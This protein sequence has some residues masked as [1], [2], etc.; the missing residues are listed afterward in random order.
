MS[1]DINEAGKDG[2]AA[3]VDYFGVGGGVDGSGGADFFDAIIFDEHVAVIDYF[4]AFHGDY[5]GAAQE[6]LAFGNFA[7]DFAERWRFFR[8]FH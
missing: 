6:E 8:A 3:D 4:F 1:V 2:F 5:A 7:R